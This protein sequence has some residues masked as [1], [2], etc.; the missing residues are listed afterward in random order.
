[1][2]YRLELGSD[3]RLS[4]S[5]SRCV[6]CPSRCVPCSFHFEI[7]YS[8]ECRLLRI[9]AYAD[10]GSG[11]IIGASL[12]DVERPTYGLTFRNARGLVRCRRLAS[13]PGGM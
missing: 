10:W 7:R 3:H 8:I 9:L 4:A 6:P 1:M 2:P 5:P 13:L 11:R 12:I